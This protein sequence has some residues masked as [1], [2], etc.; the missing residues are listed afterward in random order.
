MD[1]GKGWAELAV[2]VPAAQHQLIEA[3]RTDGR[4]AQIHLQQ[5]EEELEEEEDDGGRTTIS[6]GAKKQQQAQSAY[7][8]ALVSE[9]LP[10]VVNNLL[11]CQVGVRL[12]LTYAQHLPQCDSERPHVAGCGELPLGMT[13]AYKIMKYSSNNLSCSGVSNYSRLK[14][15]VNCC[16]AWPTF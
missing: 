16:L 13:H 2:S 10:C 15:I 11:V 8:S 3:L 9:E 7:L 12:L 1:V 5:E 14:V 6:S 4:L